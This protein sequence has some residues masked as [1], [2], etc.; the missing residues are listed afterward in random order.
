MY[1]FSADFDTLG[2]PLILF[3]YIDG[4][5]LS[6]LWSDRTVS[7][8][9]QRDRRTRALDG[10][11]AALTQLSRWSLDEMGALHIDSTA[12]F[13]NVL[14]RLCIDVA[15]EEKQASARA[16]GEEIDCATTFLTGPFPD[17]HSEYTWHIKRRLDSPYIG[18]LEKGCL[19]L[20]QIF[21]SWMPLT[22]CDTVLTPSHPDFNH[23]NC[24]VGE[25]GT[26]KAIIDWERVSIS[27]TAGYPTRSF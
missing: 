3:E 2:C 8:V 17:E 13:Q 22:A 24:I 23:S 10:L 12:T 9:V 20:I 1:A 5:L 16:C 25:D 21:I 4:I 14:P 15:A 27:P 7:A 6:D 26:L 11:A 19:M 18:D